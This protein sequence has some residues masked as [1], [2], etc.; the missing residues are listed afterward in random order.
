MFSSNRNT[1]YTSVVL[2]SVAMAIAAG[3]P[4]SPTKKPASP[5]LKSP[6]PKADSSDTID[7]EYPTKNIATTVTR[8]SVEL[9]DHAS[10]AAATQRIMLNPDFNHSDASLSSTTR[11]ANLN[12]NFDVLGIAN[13]I[14]GSISAH[15][16]RDAFV[17]NVA[18]TAFY[19]A[20]QRY[21]VMVFN[22]N[23]A[24]AYRLRGVR[25]YGS[26]NY[27]GIIFGVW[28]F[29]SGW[30]ENRGDGGYINWCFI[31]RFHRNGGH[32]SFY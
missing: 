8:S 3:A 21:H 13:A 11:A 17:K 20:R 22:L 16:N 15:Q 32:V 26:A 1:L 4:A 30:F 25:F 2:F 18:Y 5:P 31:G 7:M 6:P 19:N 14:S 10:D 9:S 27:N 23:Q 24:H 28:V 29:R 12:V